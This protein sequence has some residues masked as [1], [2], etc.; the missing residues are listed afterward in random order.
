MFGQKEDD[1]KTTDRSTTDEH[2][3][4]D[5]WYRSLKALAEQRGGH[6]VDR[7][8]PEVEAKPEAA[9][10]ASVEPGDA[11]PQTELEKRAG[12]LLERLRTLQHLGDPERDETE[13]PPTSAW[14][15]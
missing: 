6:G 9:P 15:G 11:V 12:Q 2:A 13:A 8:Q 14:Q 3:Y 10:P 1:V 7:D 4:E 5:N